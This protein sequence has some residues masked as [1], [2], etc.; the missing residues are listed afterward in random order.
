MKDVYNLRLGYCLKSI[1]VI[2]ILLFGL[3]R[4]NLHAQ[5]DDIKFERISFEERNLQSQVTCILQ[6]SKGFMWFGTRDGLLRY[7]GYSFKEF[8]HDPDD[9]NSLSYNEV[10]SIHE[11]RSGNLWIGTGAIGSDL[12]IGGLNKFDWEKERFIHYQFEP[13]NPKS[14]SNNIVKSIYEDKTGILWI[15]IF[16]GI[17]KFDLETEEFTHYRRTFPTY[18]PDI[19]GLIDHLRETNW[20][21]AS[22]LRVGDNQDTTVVFKA[23]DT[24]YLIVSMGEDGYYGL[25]DYG[26]IEAE[27]VIWKMEAHKAKHGG[28]ARK[29]RI[30]ISI[31]TF[32]PGT[33]QLRYRSDDSHSYSAWNAPMPDNPELWG[34]QIFAIPENTAK[35]IYWRLT[36]FIQESTISGGLVNTICED[37]S[38]D[39]WIGTWEEGL[40]RFDIGKEEFI[41]YKHDPDNPKSLSDN[42]VFAICEDHF[43]DLWI[44]TMNGGLNKFDREKGEFIHY[45]H[46][47]NDHNSLSSNQVRSI[48]EDKSGILWIGTAF[49]GLNIFDREHDRFYHYR[50]DPEIPKSLSDNNVLSIF[51][52]RSGTIWIGTYY[53]GLN[54]IVRERK[55]FIHH[56]KDP[57]NPNSLIN[58]YITAI[59]EDEQGVIWIGTNDGLNRFDRKKNE[60][61]HFKNVPNNTNSI[62]N[63]T[64]TA[65]YGDESGAVWIGTE[66]GL[67][68][69]EREEEIFIH[70]KSDPD[71]PSS[72]SDYY[73]N[74]IF[75]DESGV[76]WIG[77]DEGLNKFDREK[78]EFTHYKNDPD[79]HGSISSNCINTIYEDQSAI[80]WIGT[81]GGGLNKFDRKKEIFTN[82]ENDLDDS[83]SLSDNYVW[84]IYE[85]LM[86]SLWIGTGSGLNRFDRAKESFTLY[87]EKQGLP[88]DAIKGILGD[89]QGNLWLCVSRGLIK[90]NP[91]K[92]T[93]KKYDIEDSFYSNRMW[94]GTC[95]KSR[96][97]E[98]FFGGDYGFTAFYPDSIEDNLYVPPIVITDFK[99]FNKSVKI[100][101]DSP[102]KKSIIETNEIVLSYKESVFSFE[103]AALNFSKPEKNQYAYMIEGYDEDWNYIG[104]K[105]FAP[106]SKLPAGKYTF[107]VKGSNCDGVWNEKGTSIAITIAPPPWR[108]WWAY[109]LYVFALGGGFVGYIRYRSRVVRDKLA[110]AEVDAELTAARKLQASL[111]PAGSHKLDRFHL[112]GK[113]I[114][115]SEVGGDYFDFRLL[116]DGRLIVVMG[117]VSGHGLP[118]GI[119]VSMA[120]ASMVTLSRRKGSDFKETLD[121]LNAVIRRIS[122]GKLMYMTFCY[123]LIEPDRGII[124]CSANGHPFPMIA[125]KDGTITEIASIGGYPLGV[126]EEQEFKI[127]EAGFLPG[128]TL[129]IYTDGLPEQI[130]K[131]GEPWGYDNFR[132][133]FFELVSNEG[134]ESLVNGL[135]KRVSDYAGDAIQEDDMTVVSIKYIDD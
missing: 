89:T 112:V 104:N 52:D 116:D 124:G 102:L 75:E 82:Y 22:I 94:G 101:D 7:D 132:S 31:S 117:D 60:F 107:R 119:L 106:Y 19:F 81:Y 13:D 8:R 110:R 118:A 12:F 11:D 109:S 111:I 134:A 93:L 55:R 49:G 2:T 92:E 47:P 48:Y 14:L 61:G 85:D 56:K 53:E 40:F 46:D 1:L 131:N 115:A 6:D 68:R 99:M 64:I 44:G 73:I 26:W 58:N 42:C 51:E 63:N 59:Y 67:Q 10:L 77:T 86:G 120:K 4:S 9:P 36:D 54:K 123:L 33:Y 97:G 130:N 126:R 80:L 125:K 105:R 83:K 121:A 32:K 39:L 129:L 71:N 108:T 20:L 66:N 113:F 17:E 38:G 122:P 91:Q 72:I 5:E 35:N 21:V 28:G 127:I 78:G 41:N 3:N 23:G 135:L 43:G 27:E 128:D 87:G 76:L 74:S 100:S 90:F 45:K 18:H 50:S 114:P 70:Y 88:D 103:F 29:N 37:S 84:S 133:A 65:I 96:S 57:E 62:S 69:F 34:I 25:N 24:K 79:K 30:Q 98:M 15:G 16:D 95:Y